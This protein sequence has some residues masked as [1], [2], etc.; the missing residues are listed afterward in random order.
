MGF[1]NP[2]LHIVEYSKSISESFYAVT[3]HLFYVKT[4]F[5]SFTYRLDAMTRKA[6]R[7]HINHPQAV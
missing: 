3:R 1:G 7:L 2:S 6:T 5:L 4:L